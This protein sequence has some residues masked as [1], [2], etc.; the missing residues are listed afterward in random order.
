VSAGASTA[1]DADLG[2]VVPVVVRSSGR[3][4]LA[5]LEDRD[6]AVAIESP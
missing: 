4:I 5:R 6:H 3:T 1:A 2:E